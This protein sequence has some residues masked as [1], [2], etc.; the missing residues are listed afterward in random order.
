MASIRDVVDALGR[1]DGVEAVIIL[2][3]DGLP[4]SSHVANGGDPEVLAAL[5]PNVVQ[6]GSQLGQH[7]GRGDLAMGVLEFAGGLAIV[8]KLTADS[9]LLVLARSRTN[10]GPLLYDLTRYRAEIAGLL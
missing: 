1:R 10:L 6:S 9:Q 7:A 3:S 8:A 2:G 4:I 5:I